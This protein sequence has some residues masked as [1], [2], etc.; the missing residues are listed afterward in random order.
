MESKIKKVTIV[1]FEFNNNLDLNNL[2]NTIKNRKNVAFHIFCGINNELFI[3]KIF[4]NNFSNSLTITKLNINKLIGVGYNMVLQSLHFWNSLKNEDN[5]L[6]YEYNYKSLNLE[7]LYNYFNCNYSI[8]GNEFIIGDNNPYID[9]QLKSPFSEVN[10]LGNISFRKKSHMILC[11]KNV[12][13][14]NLIKFR[15]KYDLP[16]IY[17][18]NIFY[19]REDVYFMNSLDYL[20]YNLPTKLE[21]TNFTK[22]LKGIIPKEKIKLLFI[23]IMNIKYTL[24]TP[25][26]KPLGGTQ[27]CLCY[28]LKEL[29]KYE[30]F[31][32]YLMNH[33]TFETNY[34]NVKTIPIK[35]INKEYV[36]NTIYKIQPNYII[37]LNSIEILHNLHTLLHNHST[38]HDFNIPKFICWMHDDTNQKTSS[39][40]KN[41]D[42]NYH[43]FINYAPRFGGYDS[44]SMATEGKKRKIDHD[45]WVVYNNRLYLFYDD[46]F[47][48]LWLDN[49]DN[50]ILGGILHWCD[51]YSG[52]FDCP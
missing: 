36:L 12:S 7:H 46:N 39:Y 8:L 14:Q 51:E 20:G 30:I 49:K 52:T 26:E 11:L 29:S 41:I 33:N 5:L 44:Y 4:S 2:I 43:D 24:N 13:K 21:C 25:Y 10:I 17:F 3:K 18:E 32:L 1:I 15:T 9:N 38:S 47:R 31:D 23:D 42:L 28:F 50:N 37:S 22:R 34:Y 16:N 48:N 45:S 27:S 40:L 35:E 6:I 19:I